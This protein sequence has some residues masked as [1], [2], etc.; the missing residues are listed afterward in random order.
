[1]TMNK[2]GIVIH[3]EELT[4]S[5]IGMLKGTCI[6]VLG[7]HPVGGARADEKLRGFLTLFSSETFQEK[8]KKV[9]ELG[10]AVEYEMHALSWMLP[11]D[12]YEI[13]PEWFR[14]DKE[15]KRVRDFNMCVSNEEALEYI[16]GRAAELASLL[17]S[18]TGRYYFWIDDV[19]D[20]FCCCEKCRRLTPSDQAMLLYNAI[21]KGIRRADPNAR[22]CYLAYL[23]TMEVPR[24][25]RPEEGIFLEFA[26][27][28]RDTKTPLGENRCEENQRYV[29]DLGPL[30]SYFGKKDFQVL[31]YWLD[32]SLFSGWKK[33]PKKI[34]VDLDTIRADIRFYRERGA[35]GITTFGCYLSDDYQELYGKPPIGEYAGCFLQK[36]A[37]DS[38]EENRT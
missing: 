19:K 35:E 11:R 22:Q 34:A 36:P 10:I 29:R 16:S 9:R 1:M 33:P 4:D 14:E 38:A 12:L 32:N 37:A 13:H 7:L 21:L 23:D 8:L 27:M 17:R 18:D 15:K 5:M 28:Y 24:T 20:A 26:P 3:P 31:E 6:N 2:Q 25:V 30:L